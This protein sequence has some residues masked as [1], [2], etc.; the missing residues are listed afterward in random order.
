MICIGTYVY[1]S[2]AAEKSLLVLQLTCTAGHQQENHFI[3]LCQTPVVPNWQSYDPLTLRRMSIWMGLI[4]E[5]M[6]NLRWWSVLELKIQLVCQLQL[7]ELLQ[8]SFCLKYTLS[9]GRLCQCFWFKYRNIPLT[10]WSIYW[11]IPYTTGDKSFALIEI[12]IP[13]THNTNVT[14]CHSSLN[15]FVT[16]KPPSGVE[17]LHENTDQK[18]VKQPELVFFFLLL[19]LP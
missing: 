8:P 15:I 7:S 4:G 3:V 5:A 10:Q 13:Q 14:T 16:N 12:V 6:K 1:M 19:S 18:V 17:K 2:I 9:N 11:H